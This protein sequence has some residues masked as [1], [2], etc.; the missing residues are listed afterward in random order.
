MERTHLFFSL[1]LLFLSV[2][3]TGCTNISPPSERRAHADQLAAES[4][5]EKQ[6]LSTQA[7]SLIAYTP[8]NTQE[9]TGEITNKTKTL[10]IYIEG[11]GLAWISRSLISPDPTPKKPLALQLA[12]KHKIGAS[13]YLGRP[14]QYLEELN[15]QNCPKS[16]WTNARFSAEVIKASNQAIDQLKKQFGA[17]KLQLIGFSGGGAVA[18][19]VAAQRQ[20]ISR[21]VTVAGNLD[22]VTWTK[23]HRI[24][25]L[26]KSLNPADAW[27]SLENT[28][29][30]HLVGG[31]DPIIGENIAVAYQSRF[32]EN[33]KPA[34][35]VIPN[36]D[37]ACCWL[38]T[39]PKLMDE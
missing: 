22:H 27:R 28:P 23:A 5:W 12:L 8:K 11:D 34:I 7:F 30:L 13:A 38:E 4:N 15:S 21:L 17:S 33:K 19:L 18:T 9:K 6:T 20:D 29:Q 25:P 39:W 24:S 10:S 37:H 1:A 2:I 35:K 26:S 14:C 31:A 3:A 32:P 16:Y 36:F